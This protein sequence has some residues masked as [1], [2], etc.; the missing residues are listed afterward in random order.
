MR[1]YRVQLDLNR[2]QFF[3]P[4]DQE[5][6]KKQTLVFDG[7]PRLENWTPPGVYIY[8]PKLRRG[9]FLGTGVGG[10]A[11]VCDE[12]AREELQTHFEMS[13]ELLPLPHKGEMFH[14]VNVTQCINAL[15]EQR[16]EWVIGRETRARI[17]I[18]RYAFH[19]D[20]V[21]DTPLFKIPETDKSEILTAEGRFDPEDEFKPTVE[22]LGLTGLIF[23]Q[24]WTDE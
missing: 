12:R 8:Q 7:T 14:I 13:G 3:A 21:P 18:K 15:D 6:F 1:V 19:A 23:E 10:G 9:N 17:G 2:F 11:F 20:R 24:I 4:E 16:T 5:V 22:Q